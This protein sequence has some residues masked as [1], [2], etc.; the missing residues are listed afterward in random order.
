M[1]SLDKLLYEDGFPRP[2]AIKKLV[3]FKSP[4]EHAL[5]IFI[6]HDRRSSFDSSR[7]RAVSARSLKGTSVF[8][9]STDEPAIDEVA[10]KAMIGIL[11]GYVGRYSK[12][13]SFRL[14]MREKCRSCFKKGNFGNE[15]LA[16]MEIGIQSIEKIVSSKTENLD[17]ESLQ[18]SI[19]IM[20]I[21]ASVS[22]DA[23]LSA[24]A[25]LYL[26]IIYKIAK[27]DK[28]SARHLLQVFSDSP[29]FAR[30][31]LLVELWD[32]FFLPHLLHLK[33]WYNKELD[34]VVNSGYSDK[35]RRVKA[36]NQLYNEQMDIGTTLFANYYKEWLKVGAQPPP[37]PVVPLPSKST[38]PKTRRKSTESSTSHHSV[39]NK[40]L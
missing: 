40:S 17:L 38:Y 27:N 8:S 18:K 23:T 16:H 39:S 4:Q 34:F 14:S 25:H 7:Q 10:V 2:K 5:P 11:S 12:D 19:K 32:H 35:E 6:C 29:F 30:K 15:V 26:S 21:V 28:I 13:E 20:N 9:G 36:L 37:V 31:H 33:I 1:A 22:T 3:K 24:S